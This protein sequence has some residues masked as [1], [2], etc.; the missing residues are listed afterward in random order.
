ME[1]SRQFGS[2]Y[3]DTSI[4]VGTKKDI[5]EDVKDLVSQ[6]YE[7]MNNNDLSSANTLFEKNKDILD[8]Y[9]VN[10]S[11]FNRLEEEIY[12]TGV[13]AINSVSTQTI[14]VSDKEPSGQATY[15]HWIKG[16]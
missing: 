16:W 8:D 15:S 4:P 6:Y 2:N 10:S 5:D 9:I 11:Y 13:K 12:N 1:Y 14:V 7:Y 3:P